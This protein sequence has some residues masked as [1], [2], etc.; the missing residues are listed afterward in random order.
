MNTELWVASVSGAV[1]LVSALISVRA[2]RGQTLLAA[3]LERRATERREEAERQDVMGRHRDPLLWAAYDLQSRLTNI[4]RHR[5]LDKFYARGTE[6]QRRY[7]VRSTLH[8]L[9]ECLGQVELLRRR[10]QFLDL[11]NRQDNRTVMNRLTDVGAVLSDSRDRDSPLMIFRSTQRALGELV[12]DGDGC[13]GYAEFCRRLEQDAWF[14]EW[15]EPP[16]E[17]V[18]RLAAVSGPDAYRRLVRL[19][20]ALLDLI[21]FLDP[22]TER[23]PDRNRTRL[24]LT[25]TSR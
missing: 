4:V 18:R 23:F 5:F 11:G 20:N 6:W 19:Q 9:A 2:A 22:E 8:V 15:F 10:V 16:A 14:A 1:A 24:P 21:D 25:G 12:I 13:I 17:E 3:E 7:A